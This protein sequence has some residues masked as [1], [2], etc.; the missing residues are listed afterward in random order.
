MGELW[1]LYK[2]KRS[3]CRAPKQPYPSNNEHPDLN[4]QLQAEDVDESEWRDVIENEDYRQITGS[5][6]W[7]MRNSMPALMYGTSITTKCMCKPSQKALKSAM[8]LMQYAHET[9]DV[10]ITFNSHG[11]LEPVCYMDSGFNQAKLGSKPQ[12]AFVIMWMGGPIV[13]IGDRRRGTFYALVRD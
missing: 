3:G 8:H 4:D 2:D 1:N 13:P 6:L 5:L 12:Y 9:K 7:I 11:N 10:G